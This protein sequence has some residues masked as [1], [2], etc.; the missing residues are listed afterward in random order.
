M[1]MEPKYGP[2][3]TIDAP[4]MVPSHFESRLVGICES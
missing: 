3:G 1:A 4:R 2:R